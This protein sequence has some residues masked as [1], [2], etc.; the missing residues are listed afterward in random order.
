MEAAP[1]LA[2]GL[3]APVSLF[4]SFIIERNK[5]LPPVFAFFSIAW[6]HLLGLYWVERLGYWS[7]PAY[8]LAAFEIAAVVAYA[9]SAAI[10][11]IRAFSAE[12]GRLPALCVGLP[13][14]VATIAFGF[15]AY[16]RIAEGFE[17]PAQ[18]RDRIVR[19]A[20]A[21][22]SGFASAAALFRIAA[23]I[24]RKARVRGEDASGTEARDARADGPETP[25]GIAAVMAVV[26]E[27]ELEVAKLLIT[28]LSYKEIGAKMF[29]APSTVKTHVLRIYEKTG[30]SNKMQLARLLGNPPPPRAP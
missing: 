22:A 7:F 25:D 8:V 14:C 5:L 13:L 2:I 1:A 3:I 9:V 15:I 16:A 4:I 18:D 6:M 21:L 24:L 12:R 19:L 29:I 23:A 28:G 17:A 26:S 30:V 10:L 11:S 20:Y 27:R